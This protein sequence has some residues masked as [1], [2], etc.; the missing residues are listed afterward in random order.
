MIKNM[1]FLTFF[2]LIVSV[3]PLLAHPTVGSQNQAVEGVMLPSK[4]VSDAASRLATVVAQTATDS[5][6]AFSRAVAHGA[7][8]LKPQVNPS[9]A[10]AYTSNVNPLTVRRFPARSAGKDEGLKSGTPAS[11][12]YVGVDSDSDNEDTFFDAR[13]LKIPQKEKPSGVAGGPLKHG[14]IYLPSWTK[15]QKPVIAK[16]IDA[17]PASSV[18]FVVCE[19]LAHKKAAEKPRGRVRSHSAPAALKRET[20][21]RDV[22]NQVLADKK[23][24]AQAEIDT[25]DRKFKEPQ[26]KAKAFKA[27]LTP[28][29]QAN[30]VAM[31]EER[32]M[33]KRMDLVQAMRDGKPDD[34]ISKLN[35]EAQDLKRMVE[36][37]KR[38]GNLGVA[39]MVEG[40]R[41]P[42]VSQKTIEEQ[43]EQ[44]KKL[45]DV[46]DE[47]KQLFEL[48]RA[49]L[50][51]DEMALEDDRSKK[52]EEMH[53]LAKRV[54]KA[55]QLLADMKKRNQA[56]APLVEKVEK[57]AAACSRQKAALENHALRMRFP[58]TYS[59]ARQHGH[60]A[61]SAKLA[62]SSQRPTSGAEEAAKKRAALRHREAYVGKTLEV[63]PLKL[64][65]PENSKSVMR[66]VHVRPLGNS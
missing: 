64:T 39:S 48:Q 42:Q 4:K 44:G 56:P 60:Q 40:R 54:E 25:A 13:V 9:T 35:D 32:A 18:S 11:V 24:S 27:A 21:A 57:L 1:R 63:E 28:S 23:A 59:Q 12:D 46:H 52:I 7:Y 16:P 30:D 31:L 10:S 22:R 5:R 19:P 41:V 26:E 51:S 20:Y 3:C 8:G 50:E 66:P 14:E 49:F 29:A 34:V 37:A 45:K 17:K 33:L 47:L 53:K 58:Q 61:A 15:T 43:L 36:I 38:S 55:K 62:A 6:H 2:S 65:K